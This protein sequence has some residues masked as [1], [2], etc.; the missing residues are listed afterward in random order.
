MGVYTFN[1]YYVICTLLFCSVQTAYSD[2]IVENTPEPPLFSADSDSNMVLQI[3]PYLWAAGL[4]GDIS[5]FKHAPTLDVKKSFSDVVDDL[6]F[7]GFI[8]VWGR[9]DH[10]VFSAD[11]MYINTTDSAGRGPLSAFQLPGSGVVIPPGASVRAEVDSKQFMTSLQGGYRVVDTKE[12]TF[13]ILAGIRFWQ[14]S[15]DVSVKANHPAIG[16]HSASHGERFNW[17]DPLFGIRAFVPATEN[18]SFQLQADVGG[19]GAGLK[20]TWSTLATV[21]Y[22]LTDRLS[23]SVGYKVLDV[24]YDRSGHVYDVRLNGPVFGLTYRF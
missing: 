3:T 9:R 5:P 14:I 8:N 12:I 7:G 20:S 15:T 6:N 22:V 23:T 18:L 24:H 1:K 2:D 17:I 13:D 16:A 11:V 19:F 21:N 4:K 10:F